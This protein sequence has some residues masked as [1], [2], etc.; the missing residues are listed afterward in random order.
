[1]DD[2]PFSSRAP[3]IA[4][5]SWLP[6]Q[7]QP[8][9]LRP[10]PPG[11]AVDP[12][13]VISRAPL[14]AILQTWVPGPAQ[15][16]AKGPV[17]PGS[18][19]DP[20]PIRQRGALEAIVVAWLEP[21]RA[22]QPRNLYAALEVAV[23][24][25]APFSRAARDVALLS[26]GPAPPQP[27][28]AAKYPQAGPVVVEFVP[29]RRDAI[30][31]ASWAQPA[32][33]PQRSRGLVLAVATADNPPFGLRRMPIAVLEAWRDAP[34]FQQALRKLIQQGAA[35]TL[36]TDIPTYPITVGTVL[37]QLAAGAQLFSAAAPAILIAAAALPAV[38]AVAAVPQVHAIAAAPV[39]YR[40]FLGE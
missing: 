16:Q 15:P 4:L 39:V 18:A 37:Y 19:V 22:R 33:L 2:P 21:P 12:P 8:Q 28:V 14:F 6:A 38:H 26:W 17:P 3:R 1:V 35:P 24:E 27:Q 9:Q 13:P 34:A 11:S 36:F 25:T 32:P 31:I 23:A 30:A 20:P 40:I 7:P 10:V 5:T 29:S